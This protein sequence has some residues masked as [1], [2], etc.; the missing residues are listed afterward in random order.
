MESKD[1]KE[2]Q[3]VGSSFWRSRTF[4][5]LR[6]T[7]IAVG[8]LCIIVYVVLYILYHDTSFGAVADCQWSA[9]V[10]TW[11]DVNADG[12]FQEGEP[13]LPGIN[14]LMDDTRTS[15][16]NSQGETKLGTGFVEGCWEQNIKITAEEPAGYRQTTAGTHF[17]S[18]SELNQSFQF[19]FTFLPGVPTLTPI[20]K[21]QLSCAIVPEFTWGEVNSIASDKG[22]L[23]IASSGKVA[24]LDFSTNDWNVYPGGKAYAG[25]AYRIFV[26]PD[27]SVWLVTLENVYRLNEGRWEE[28]SPEPLRGK[29]VS[30]IVWAPNDGVW[31]FPRWAPGIII[32]NPHTNI[33]TSDESDAYLDDALFASD[34]KDIRLNS[35]DGGAIAPDGKVWGVIKAGKYDWEGDYYD[36]VTHK[37]VESPTYYDC[38]NDMKFDKQGGMWLATCNAGLLYIPDPIKGSQAGWYDYLHDIGFKSDTVLALFL[39]GD[40]QL[41]VGTAEGLARCQIENH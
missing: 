17:A 6:R 1:T 39:Q 18:G 10:F 20:P 29:V 22:G 36:P 24:R 31:F 8:S 23:W 16:T 9:K 4:R 25:E 5:W 32:W 33:W 30:S 19:G 35:D 13:P 14:I 41:W 28:F 27:E 11:I 3:K 37:I 34:G 21:P 12:I 40:N 2:N 38:Y 26:G 15:V 7:I